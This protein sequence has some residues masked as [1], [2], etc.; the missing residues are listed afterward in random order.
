MKQ[1][2]SLVTNGLSTSWTLPWPSPI[3]HQPPLV[4]HSSLL[5]IGIVVCAFPGEGPAPPSTFA[6]GW[7]WRVQPVASHWGLGQEERSLCETQADRKAVVS[8][9]KVGMHPAR[10]GE[11]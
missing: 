8:S 4:L 9:L 2:V 3:R 6:G 7:A 10:Q 11:G 5:T 1:P